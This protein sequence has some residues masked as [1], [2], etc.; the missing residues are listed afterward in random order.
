[1][2]QQIQEEIKTGLPVMQAAIQFKAFRLIVCC[3]KT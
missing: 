3:R 2:P 1:M